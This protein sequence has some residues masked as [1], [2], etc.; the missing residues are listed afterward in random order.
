MHTLVL[1]RHA[2]SD[3][4]ALAADRDRPLAPRGRRQAPETGT[5]LAA[6]G[7]R[8]ELA[9]VSPARRARET[10]EL[11]AAQLDGPPREVIEPAAYTFDGDELLAVVR[12]LPEDV[13]VVTL[14]GHNPAMEE[15]VEALTGRGVR[16]PTSALAVVELDAWSDAGDGGARLSVAGRPDGSGLLAAT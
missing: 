1:V 10:W 16:M 9:V 6:H 3:W 7:P 8:S 14:V 4:S 11:V 2:K 15:L 13:S 12:E 5:W